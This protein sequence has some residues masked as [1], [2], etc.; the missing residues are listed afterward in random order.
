MDAGQGASVDLRAYL[1]FPLPQAR[2][3]SAATAWSEVRS[4]RFHG[5]AWSMIL[6]VHLDG[7]VEAGRECRWS[8]T[9]RGE[10]LAAPGCRI[11]SL[12]RMRWSSRRAES[13]FHYQNTK[14]SGAIRETARTIR[15]GSG[16]SRAA[17]RKVDGYH[18]TVVVRHLDIGAASLNSPV[19]VCLLEALEQ[20][21]VSRAC[22]VYSLNSRCCIT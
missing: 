22:L 10:S 14:A 8:G 20:I 12:L 19:S 11:A 21:V 2:A 13:S 5:I 9:E 16:K 17:L 18:A 1:Y 3:A 7:R 6:F 4:G 15:E